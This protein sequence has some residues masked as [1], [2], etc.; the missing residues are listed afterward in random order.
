MARQKRTSK[1]IEHA[2]QRAASMA[3]ISHL[4]DLGNSLTLDNYNLA[5]TNVQAKL[6][7]YNTVLSAVDAAHRALKEAERSLADLSENMLIAVAYKYGKNSTE[8]EMAGGVRKTDRKRPVRK[9]KPEPV[10]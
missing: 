10:S 4:L 2:Q 7:N 9:T 6:D 1:T 8:Y 3:S 5:I